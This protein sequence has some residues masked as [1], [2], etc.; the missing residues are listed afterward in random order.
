MGKHFVWINPEIAGNRDSDSSA[1]ALPECDSTQPHTASHPVKSVPGLDMK[2]VYSIFTPRIPTQS[3]CD[4]LPDFE[5]NSNTE[6]S[7]DVASA[8]DEDWMPSFPD[9]LESF[10]ED[11]EGHSR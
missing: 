8:C 1:A 6:D 5:D 4:A 9:W 10:P 7:S 3:T 11:D 2:K